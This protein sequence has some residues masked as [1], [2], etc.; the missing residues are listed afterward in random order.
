M[1]HVVW[2]AGAGIPIPTGFEIHH[3]DTNPDNN[4]WP[5][6]FCLYELDH[7]KL[8]NGHRLVD[9]PEEDEPF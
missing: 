2:L 3:K 1:S 4:A 8:H 9:E 7:R 6:L 5:N